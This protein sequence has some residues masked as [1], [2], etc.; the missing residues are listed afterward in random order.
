M[1]GRLVPHVAI[2]SIV[3]SLALGALPRLVLCIGP[4]GHDQIELLNVDCCHRGAAPAA[5]VAE[6]ESGCGDHCT[7]TP[8]SGPTVTSADNGHQHTAGPA[9]VS[10][11]VATDFASRSSEHAVFSARFATSAPFP[12]ALRTTIILC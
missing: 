9:M 4:D 8:I 5:A 6:R 10:V 12:H 2:V 3:L 7:D 11:S 1:N